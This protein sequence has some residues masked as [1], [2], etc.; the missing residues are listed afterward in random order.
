MVSAQD[1]TIRGA[2]EG[3]L[4]EIAAIYSH[5]SRHAYSTFETEARPA[6]AWSSR[7]SSADPFL[8]AVRGG[9]V[10]GFAY[11]SP[12]RERP[13]YHRTRETSVYLHRGARGLGAG[14]LLYAELLPRLRG[15]GIRTALALIALPNDAS[16]RLHVSAGYEQVGTLREVGD[17]LGRWIDVGVFQAML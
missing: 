5:E 8:V 6:S 11:A 14:T 17:K 16:V 15:Q 9:E 7:L 2:R 1:I 3:D 12:F 10:V 13:A 4:E